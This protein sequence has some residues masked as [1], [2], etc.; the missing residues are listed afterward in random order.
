MTNI[1]YFE[2]IQAS[3]LWFLKRYVVSLSTIIVKDT[4]Q[5]QGENIISLD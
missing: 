2:E 1:C 3:E 5:F 4:T